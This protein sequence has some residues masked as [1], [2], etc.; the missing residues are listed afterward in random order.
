MVHHLITVP[1][2]VIATALKNYN[3]AVSF[4]FRPQLLLT[5]DFNLLRDTRKEICDMPWAE[6]PCC[7][8]MNLYFGIKRAHEEIGHLNIETTITQFQGIL[9]STLHWLLHC[10]MNGNTEMKS[11]LILHTSYSRLAV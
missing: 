4:L 5:A 7:E 11:I 9:S 2:D 3:K 6:P 1:C 8:A 10:L